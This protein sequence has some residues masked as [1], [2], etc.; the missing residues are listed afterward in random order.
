MWLAEAVHELNFRQ[1]WNI[2]L[3]AVLFPKTTTNSAIKYTYHA[4]FFVIFEIYIRAGICRLTFILFISHCR[5][6]G[7]F[8]F[9][10]CFVNILF[11]TEMHLA[12][13]T[14]GENRCKSFG[15]LVE[16]FTEFTLK[17]NKALFLIPVSRV[18]Y[19]HTF[20]PIL[21]YQKLMHAIIVY[22]LIFMK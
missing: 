1:F 2:I 16:I 15:C 21:F 4:L 8:I 10:F 5:F 20:F 22:H 14:Q 7:I 13:V 9:V 12:I 6:L 11:T 17:T 19:W 3:L 18:T